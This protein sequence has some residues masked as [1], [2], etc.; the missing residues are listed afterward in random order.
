MIDAG[1]CAERKPWELSASAEPHEA[2]LLRKALRLHLAL[3]GLPEVIEAA[4][5]C[6]SELMSNVINHV[7][8]GTPVTLAVSMSGTYVRI[9][10]RDPDTR[11]LP[12]LLDAQCGMESGR[13]MALIDAFTDHRWGVILC[14]DSKVVWCELATDLVVPDGHSD[15][16]Q[17]ERAEQ[18]IS[19]YGS[20]PPARMSGQGRLPVAQA[21]E[22][23][24]D[25]IAD[26]L[27]WLR[28][29]GCDP[30]DALDRAQ[31]HFEAEAGAVRLE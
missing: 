29:H 10:M 5:M 6:V 23:A 19:L 25:L 8:I 20:V 9:E 4:Q 26:L 12:I 2:V 15:S 7:G 16:P 17:M 28:V 24:I 21:E 22:A 30:D 11:A 31:M 1:D 27:H 14:G 13:G 3:W 18:C